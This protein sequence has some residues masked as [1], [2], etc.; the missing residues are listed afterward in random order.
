MLF[1]SWPCGGFIITNLMG[2]IKK[3]SL[4]D[5]RTQVPWINSIEIGTIKW[6]ICCQALYPFQ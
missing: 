2:Q 5:Y 6:V 1:D 4:R 3:Q